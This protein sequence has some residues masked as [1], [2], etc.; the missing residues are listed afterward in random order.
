MILLG[1]LFSVA[2]FLI[3]L[4]LS[5]AFGHDSRDMYSLI[6]IITTP[7]FFGI[8]SLL[9]GVIYSYQDGDVS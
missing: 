3:C 5:D 8:G 9:G 7:I 6:Y 1:T 2:N 4:S